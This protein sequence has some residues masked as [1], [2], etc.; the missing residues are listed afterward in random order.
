MHSGSNEER[1]VLDF[2]GA[3]SMSSSLLRLNC[4]LQMVLWST[5]MYFVGI[6]V[7]TFNW[8]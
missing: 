1:E 7:K 5:L 2:Q 4:A 6:Q 3:K 8:K